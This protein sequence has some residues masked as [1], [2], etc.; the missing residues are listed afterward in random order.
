MTLISIFLLAFFSLS[1]INFLKYQPKILKKI[2]EVKGL[3]TINTD[4]TPYP[5]DALKIG[6]YQTPKS[7]QTTFKTGK[8]Q[9]EVQDFYKNIYGGKS[10][11]LISEKEVDHT[12]TF[13]YQ[14]E[15][16]VVTIVATAEEN[17]N[18]TIVSI[19]IVN[20]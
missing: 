19:E 13:S 8:T 3:S 11:K 5:I 1:Y 10:W 18:Y 2:E 14:K 7:Q 9:T 17:S 20:K 15:K 12:I 4:D 16:E 6:F